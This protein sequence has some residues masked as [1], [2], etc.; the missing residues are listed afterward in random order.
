M[1][2]AN[3]TLTNAQRAAEPIPIGSPETTTSTRRFYL[4]PAAVALDATR[5]AFSDTYRRNSGW[6][7][8][9]RYQIAADCLRPLFREP[10]VVFVAANA[11]SMAF[12]L[13]LQAGVCEQD[14]R[15]ID[16][17]LQPIRSKP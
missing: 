14:T 4:R 16:P 6:R 17:T 10:Q 8:A 11:V 5:S 2:R 3:P 1:Q 13:D 12:H 9:L 15:R 7:H